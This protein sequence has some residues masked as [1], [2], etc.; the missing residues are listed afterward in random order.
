MA[1]SKSFDEKLNACHRLVHD[2]A[3][4]AQIT[5]HMVKPLLENAPE[6][7][8][9]GYLSQSGIFFRRVLTRHLALALSRLLEEPNERGR[10]GIT[11]S[12]AGLLKMAR[13]E[14]VL[15][16]AKIEKFNADFEKIKAQAA[17]GE[18]DLVKTLRELRTGQIAHSLIPHEE[19]TDQLWAHDLFHFAE[20]IFGLVEDIEAALLETTG[21]ALPD[22]RENADKFQLSAD[23]FWQA[24]RMVKNVPSGGLNCRGEKT[25]MDYSVPATIHGTGRG[26]MAKNSLYNAI[27]DAIALPDLTPVF[28]DSN[29]GRQHISGQEIRSIANSPE[30]AAYEANLLARGRTRD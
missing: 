5:L 22:L 2:D 6:K 16:Q 1:T 4:E 9:L 11:A 8:S 14:S 3:F 21:I 30:F 19:P 10:T 26:S 13:S 23:Q 18:Y 28:I 25:L 20:L 24:V 7:I 12:I 27:K 17:A 15:D 29:D